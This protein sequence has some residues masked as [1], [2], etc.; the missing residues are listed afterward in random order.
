MTA[1]CGAGQKAARFTLINAPFCRARNRP[2]SRARQN[3]R[4]CS[5]YAIQGNLPNYTGGVM[6]DLRRHPRD[7]P[8]G[9]LRDRITG[10]LALVSQLLH[11]PLKGSG[12]I[13]A[14]HEPE[15]DYIS[16]G[17]ARVRHDFG[18]KLSMPRQSTRGLRSVCARCINGRFLRC[19]KLLYLARITISFLYIASFNKTS[20]NLSIDKGVIFLSFLVERL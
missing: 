2:T 16:K 17:K 10:K 6:R 11:Q 20:S 4:R 15:L 9:P 13:Y 19:L 7:T 18:T 1:P 5:R 3:A 14:L 12:D 8:S